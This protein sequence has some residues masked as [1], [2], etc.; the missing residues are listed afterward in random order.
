MSVWLE[1][2]V[3]EGRWQEIADDD[4]G[5]IDADLQRAAIEILQLREQCAIEA[6]TLHDFGPSTQCPDCGS[7]GHVLHWY[8]LGRKDAA[9]AI[10]KKIK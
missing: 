7:S 8:T 4:T 9:A 3:D 6:E 5:D 2:A 1:K 10:R